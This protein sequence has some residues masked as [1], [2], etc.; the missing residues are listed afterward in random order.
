MDYTHTHLVLTKY[1]KII[2]CTTLAQLTIYCVITLEDLANFDD[3]P[4]YCKPHI[5]LKERGHRTRSVG[6]C[7]SCVGNHCEHTLYPPEAPKSTTDTN[8][9]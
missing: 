1:V 7:Y 8:V 4:V 3:S 9:S 6:H 2:T 5:K